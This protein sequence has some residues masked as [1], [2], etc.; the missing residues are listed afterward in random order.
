MAKPSKVVS[1]DAP[2][3]GWNAFDSVDN[4]PPTS[5]II[6]DNLIPSAGTVN[7]R[8]GTTLFADTGTSL[9]VE[10]LASLDTDTTSLLIA[11][12]LSA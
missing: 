4:M 3:D 9:P 7:T 5:A 1:I 11:A 6:L 8:K 12:R 10:T 2:I